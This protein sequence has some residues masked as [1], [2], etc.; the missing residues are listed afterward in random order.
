M[1][2]WLFDVLSV[3]FLQLDLLEAVMDRAL[4]VT[5]VVFALI[6]L[7]L[8]VCRQLF[9]AMWFALISSLLLTAL[10]RRNPSMASG[11]K[12]RSFFAGRKN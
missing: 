6:S 9:V 8:M 3:R 12:G 11:G 2:Y 5:S 7:V 4:F 1:E 10:R